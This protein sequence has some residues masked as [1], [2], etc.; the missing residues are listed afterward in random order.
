[1]WRRILLYTGIGLFFVLIIVVMTAGN[2]LKHPIFTMDDS[3]EMVLLR[4]DQEI[5]AQSWEA[6]KKS[7]DE[8][9]QA[10]RRV[11]PVVQ[12]SSERDEMRFVEQQFIRLRAA[13]K[14]EDQMQAEIEQELMRYTLRNLGS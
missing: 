12:F 13:I 5:A 2:F 11:L 10:W 9:E 8:L 1:M 3:F 4:L 14:Y 6:A 7:V